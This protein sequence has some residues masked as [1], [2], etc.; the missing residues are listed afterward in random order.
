MKRIIL[1]ITSVSICV[2]LC[3]CSVF[4]KDMPSIVRTGN[5]DVIEKAVSISDYS[6]TG[7][8]NL[9]SFGYGEGKFEQ[10]LKLHENPLTVSD[11]VLSVQLLAREVNNGVNFTADFAKEIVNEYSFGCKGIPNYKVYSNLEKALKEFYAL[12]GEQ[13]LLQYEQINNLSPHVKNALAKWISAATKACKIIRAQTG[14]LDKRAF[15]ILSAFTHSRCATSEIDD[16]ELMRKLWQNTNEKEMI[17]AGVIMTNATAV[18]AH[19][20]EGKGNF[21]TNG[22]S[23]N[24]STPIGDIIIGT[25]GD[26]EYTSPN[27]LILIDEGG[28]DRYYGA[29]ATTTS[30]ERCISAV[31]D[32]G[33]NDC[34]SSDDCASQGCGILGVGLLFDMQ[35]DDKYTATRLSQGCAILGTGIV[36]DQSGCDSYSC[37]VTGQASGFYGLAIL[38]DANGDDSYSGYGFVQ[39]SAGNRCVAFLIDGDGNDVYYTPEDVPSNYEKLE[40]DQPH[41]GKSG[42][43]SQGC[44]WGQRSVPTDERGIAGG[45]AAVIDFSGNDRFDA[46]LWAQ[47]VGYW[48]GIGFLYNEG[49]NDS[50]NAY[51]YSQ[52]SVAHYGVGAIVDIGGNDSYHLKK[53]AGL[54]FV[55]DRGISM[56]IDD[57]GIDAYSCD[58]S[59]FAVANSAYDE[60]GVEN[61]DMTYAFFIDTQGDDVYSVMTYYECFGFGRGGFFFDVDGNDYYMKTQN[62]EDNCIVFASEQK[63]GGVFSDTKREGDTLPFAEFFEKAKVNATF[64]LEK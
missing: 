28:D 41:L 20:L 61:Q 6:E 25:S 40:Y 26:D 7:L 53:G 52:A 30:L 54:S 31:I 9:D 22:K 55:W 16:I 11:Y 37:D 57:F 10:Y 34:Y 59:S 51:Y 23:V 15:E 64:N 44:A 14:K 27:S 2:S 3:S 56:L 63:K 19:T 5:Y 29:V 24:V 47:G 33:G 32:F 39:A 45:I 60:K 35:G 49:G 18:L 8:E 58:G 38:S 21:T 17:G 1:W 42:S 46:G 4:K 43:F 36:Y 62:G 12:F 13:E 50:Y 48:S